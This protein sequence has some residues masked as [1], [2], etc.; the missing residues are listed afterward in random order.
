MNPNLTL[1]LAGQQWVIR[2]R[3]TTRVPALRPRRSRPTTRTRRDP[4]SGRP[5]VAPEGRF[6]ESW[7]LR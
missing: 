6:V 5:F 3:T 4:P 7:G 1:D 2:Q